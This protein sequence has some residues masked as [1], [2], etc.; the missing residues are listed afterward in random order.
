ML[1]KVCGIT[2]AEDAAAA[3]AAGATAL[4]FVFWPSSPRFVP[5][6]Q[7]ATIART[8]PASVLKVGVFVDADRGHIQDVAAAVGL[9][10]IQLHGGES[11]DAAGALTLPVWKAFGV[12][13]GAEIT[14]WPSDMMVLLDA[15][16]PRAKGGTG[17]TVDWAAAAEFARQ[18]AVVLAGGLTPEN[19]GEAIAR[20]HPRG[21]D[22]SSGVEQAPGI[23]DH[24]KVRRFVAAARAG[25]DA[26]HAVGARREDA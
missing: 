2:R 18:R 13:D 3:V 23:K 5:P 22:V 26:L 1:I 14:S 7:A 8:V 15:I 16:D 17:R 25:F 12:D 24:E 19:V 4:G 10:V 11:R 20:V 6:A 9:D 21:V